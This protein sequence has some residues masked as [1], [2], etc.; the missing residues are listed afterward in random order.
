[1]Y[2]RVEIKN[3]GGGKHQ[4]VFNKLEMTDSGEIL[5][6]SGELTSSCKLEVKKGESKPEIDFGDLVEAPAN[7]PITFNVPFKGNLSYL[8][9]IIQLH[10]PF[11]TSETVLSLN[12]SNIIVRL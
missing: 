5:C 4:L 2:F 12:C 1:M 8:S 6:K 3:L 9:N 11:F 10:S 7:H